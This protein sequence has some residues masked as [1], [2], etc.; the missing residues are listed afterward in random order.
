M[1]ELKDRYSI[2]ADELNHR[3]ELQQQYHDA[4]LQ[5]AVMVLEGA[6]EKVLVNLGVDVTK[7]PETIKM[8]Q[9]L[10]GI[11][12][13]ELQDFPGIFVTLL[14]PEP[15]PYAWI[16]DVKLN[17]MGSYSYDIQWFQKEKMTTVEGGKIA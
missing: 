2:S 11:E 17:N 16:S 5:K 14:F 6:I 7:D 1:S 4:P 3:M 8:Q 9:Q 10:L 15:T 13:S 12:I